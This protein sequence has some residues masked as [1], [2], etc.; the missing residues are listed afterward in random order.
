MRRDV[1]EHGQDLSTRLTVRAMEAIGRA[2]VPEIV[3]VTS[4]RTA[5]RRFGYRNPPPIRLFSRSG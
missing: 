4:Y 3:K 2:D 5:L 1:L